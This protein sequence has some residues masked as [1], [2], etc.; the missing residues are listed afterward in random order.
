MSFE[1]HSFDSVDAAEADDV[2]SVA[3][4]IRYSLIRF[5]RLGPRLNANDVSLF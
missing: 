2:S 3:R 4:A 5:D 1:K